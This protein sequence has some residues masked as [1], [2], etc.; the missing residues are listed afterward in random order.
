ML[1]CKVAYFDGKQQLLSTSTAFS[2]NSKIPI[3]AFVVSLE[4][5]FNLYPNIY[6]D[7]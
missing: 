4:Q 2:E 7:L 3:V 1:S 6:I 5:R